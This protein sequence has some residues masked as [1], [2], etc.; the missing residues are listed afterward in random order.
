M[1]II[2][3]CNR[4]Y[5]YFGGGEFHVQNLSERMVKLGHEVCVYT[6]DPTQQLPK[7]EILNGVKINR[8]KSFAPND[9]YFFSIDLYRSLAREEF[10]I[11]HGHDLNGFPLLAAALNKGNKSFFATLHVGAF[12]SYF[13]TLLRFPYDRVIMHKFLSRAHRIICV[14]A[15][16]KKVYQN[17]INLPESKFVIIP[18]GYD[19]GSNQISNLSNAFGNFRTILSVGRLEKSKGFH[20]L[21][22]SFALISSVPEFKDVQ[23]IIVGKGPYELHLRHLISKLGL[24]ERIHIYQNV[25]RHRLIEL[26]ANCTVF[27]LLSNYESAGLAVWDAFA[28]KK[29]TITST[30]A[31]LAEYVAEGYSIGIS[32]PPNPEELAIKI[33]KVLR[34]PNK[35]CPKTF[36]MLSWN[37]VAMKTISL[38]KE[39]L[40]E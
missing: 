40:I 7:S 16:E 29:P 33:Q 10:D 18:N 21:L 30:E 37:E 38:Y 4:Y 8:F 1:K 34:N 22:Q 12:S 3:A 25:H 24:T 14:S 6:T 13:R 26:Y 23:L 11:V 35:Y 28:L 20:Y 32:L 27:V 36:K 9:S 5:P 15:Y 17:I 39:A 2:H 19:S 31:V